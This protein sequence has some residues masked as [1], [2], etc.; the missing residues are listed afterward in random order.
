MV[1]ADEEALAAEREAVGAP[2][3]E[4]VGRDRRQLPQHHLSPG[5]GGGGGE[6]VL[7]KEAPAASGV[8]LDGERGSI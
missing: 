5:G 2:E 7:R 8:D 6:R 1:W 4:E 3:A